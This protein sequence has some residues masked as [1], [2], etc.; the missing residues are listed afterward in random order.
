MPK[1]VFNSLLI[2][3]ITIT[4]ARVIDGFVDMGWE[5][6]LMS[7]FFLFALV[8]FSFFIEPTVKR[9]FDD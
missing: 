4:I 2:T 9:L 6:I 1:R 3:A 8:A 7:P 5:D